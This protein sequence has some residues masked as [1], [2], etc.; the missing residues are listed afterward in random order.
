MKALWTILG[1]VVVIGAVG[2]SAYNGIVARHETITAKWAQVENQ[3][4]RR[5]DLI[6]NLV[7]TVKRLR[8]P[9]KD[10]FGRRDQ[11]AFAM[12]QGRVF[13]RQGQGAG[14]MDSAISRLLL[15]VENYPNL[16]GTRRSCSFRMNWPERRTALRSKGC[17]TMKRSGIITSPSECSPAISLRGCSDINR[18]RSISRRKKRRSQSQKW[19]FDPK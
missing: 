4:Q 16:K 3:L 12:G 5:N 8:R 9:R 1:I 17:A 2:I 13:G 19:N 10:G 6:P 11:R 15:V 14:A 7:N 18:R